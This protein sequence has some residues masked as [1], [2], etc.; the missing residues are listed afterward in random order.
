MSSPL[1]PV[2]TNIFMSFNKAKFYLRYVNDILA[3]FDKEQDSLMIKLRLLLKYDLFKKRISSWY[4]TSSGYLYNV[5]I[6][7]LN[8]SKKS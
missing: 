5:K 7:I 3:A 6:K 1:A 8:H 4:F 2:L